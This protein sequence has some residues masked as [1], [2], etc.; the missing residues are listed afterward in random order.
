VAENFKHNRIIEIH[1]LYNQTCNGQLAIGIL[2]FIG[3]LINIDNIM[4][5]LPPEYA[6]GKN[7]I[8]ILSTGYL[9][10]MAT[11]IN[12]VI[13]VNSNYYKYDTYFVFLLVIVTIITNYIFIPLYGISGSAIATAITVTFSNLIRYWLLYNKYQMQPYDTNS[14]KIIAIGLFSFI[15]GYLIP[16]MNNL[17]FDIVI[18]SLLT[19]VFFI[20]LILKSEATPDI[21]QKIRKNLKRFL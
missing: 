6:S 7:V 13:I 12:Q 5:L 8:L 16:Y 17:Y 21:N 11:G 9:V 14:I 10:E 18:R 15:I 19:T 1:K 20:L 3:I 2:L 4:Q